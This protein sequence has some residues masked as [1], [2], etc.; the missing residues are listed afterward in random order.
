MPIL[1]LSLVVA[2]VLLVLVL[3]GVGLFS[4][5]PAAHRIE[6]RELRR[7]TRA[8]RGANP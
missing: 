8:R 1:M 3:A 7:R 2:F 6:E 5:T 4:L